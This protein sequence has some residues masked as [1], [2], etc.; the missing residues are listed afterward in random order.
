[1]MGW[2][3]GFMAAGAGAFV[4]TLWAV[5]SESAAAFA[6]TF[7][8]ALTAGST[9]GEAC[10]QARTETG[11]HHDDPTW[12]A[13]SVYGDPAAKPWRSPPAPDDPEAKP[14]T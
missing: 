11:R 13:Y 12:L 10:R 3:Q 2:A 14:W 9:L 4:G 1:M 6:E 8:A 7:Y 5:R